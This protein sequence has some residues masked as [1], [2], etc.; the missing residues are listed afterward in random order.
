M[1]EGARKS[2]GTGAAFLEHDIKMDPIE[3]SVENW[4]SNRFVTVYKARVADKEMYCEDMLMQNIYWGGEMFPEMNIPDVVDYYIRHGFGGFLRYDVVNGKPKANP[5]FYLGNDNKVKQEG[6]AEMMQYIEIH[7]NR[8]RHLVILEE[9]RD[10]EGIETLKDYDVFAAAM[11]CLLGRKR[12][13]GELLELERQTE[14]SWEF[15]D[16]F[17]TY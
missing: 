3:I 15:D 10:I 13:K 7:G 4:Q 11:G 1:P 5:G 14:S 12:G 9:C 16:F 8:E 6:F 17:D 2:D